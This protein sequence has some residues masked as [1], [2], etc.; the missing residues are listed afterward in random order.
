MKRWIK[1][2]LVFSLVVLVLIVAGLLYISAQQS[3][4]PVK[5]IL[6]QS[7]KS[8]YVGLD[9]D[10]Q[11]KLDDELKE[12]NQPPI[13]SLSPE[14]TL[15]PTLNIQ[16]SLSDNVTNI[17][18]LGVDSRQFQMQSQTDLIMLVNV[19]KEK[20]SIKM[21]SFSRDIYLNIPGYVDNRLNEALI[22][23]GPE[24]TVKT[25]NQY[26]GLNI[27]YYVVFDFKSAEDIMNMIGKISVDVEANE[28]DDLNSK[29]QELNRI[30]DNKI[31]SPLIKEPGVQILD[32]RQAVA[33][34]RVRPN[35]SSDIDRTGRQRKVLLGLL[36]QVKKLSPS[37]I[38]N[39]INSS[40]GAFYT[41]IPTIQYPSFLLNM[42]NQRN[43][44]MDQLTIPIENSYVNDS[45]V[46][47]NFFVINFDTNK[48]ALND[49]LNN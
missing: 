25:I 20:K 11:N 26:F 13:Q 10:V 33:Y 23:G 7:N 22:Y 3:N 43:S 35:N 30:S 34:A 16:P 19:N 32:G 31:T 38:P 2:L 47:M 21:V 5:K 24:L 36:Q 1:T 48:K 49:F 12:I 44:T 42:Y 29:I 41:N 37:E 28:I 14:P 40:L 39:I 6:D 9:N 15:A 4:N 27:K 17:L 8:K 18:V 45:I 46:Q